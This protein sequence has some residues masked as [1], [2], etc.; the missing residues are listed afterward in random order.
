MRDAAGAGLLR[1][2]PGRAL[3]SAPLSRTT[4]S[5]PR[6]GALSRLPAR[7]RAL[8]RRRRSRATSCCFASAAASPM[9]ASSPGR[10]ADHHP[11]LPCRPASCSRSR[12]R[13]TA[14]LAERLPTALNSPRYWASSDGLS[15]R[16][17]EQRQ[18]GLHRL[19]LQTSVSRCRSR[20]SGAAT[21]SPATS[22]G[23][24]ISRPTGGSGKGAARAA[25]RLAAATTPRLHLPRR[26]DHRRCA[27]GR[28]AASASSGKDQ[29]IYILAELGLGLFDGTTPQ[30]VWPYLAATYPVEGARLSGHRLCRGGEATS[31]ATPPRSAT[32]IS[33]SSAFSPAPAPTAIDADPALVIYDFLTNAQYGCGFDPASID[34][35]TLFGSGGDASLQT[36]CKSL[37][38]S[39][40]A[41]AD[42][43]GAGVVDPRPAGCKSAIAP[44]SGAAASSSSFPTA[45][46]RSPPATA[47]TYQHQFSIPTPIPPSTGG[48]AAVRHRRLAR[49]SSSPTAASSTRKRPRAD[50]HRRQRP[51]RR[52]RRTAFDAGDL[53]FSVGDEGKPVTITYHRSGPD[54]LSRR[55]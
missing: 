17:S 19:Q 2:R 30:D 22:S 9:A 38:L 29:S 31:S 43:P 26:P 28:S 44:R 36:Y 23:T 14:E 20:S 25:S 27:K 21:R 16:S 37:G 54:R 3:R 53:I 51:E 6:R 34:S 32:T 4:G 52:R 33:R 35:S 11:R 7:A 12:S 50:L 40:F 18:A 46:P 39:L 55:T 1:P 47:T 42:Q 15:P 10:T 5:A 24:P 48:A 8:G 41:G 45:T 49:R 13:A